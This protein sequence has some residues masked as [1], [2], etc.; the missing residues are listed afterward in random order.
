MR[1]TKLT[2][3]HTFCAALLCALVFSGCASADMRKNTAL[4]DVSQATA[5]Q[6]NRGTQMVKDFAAKHGYDKFGQVQTYA[7]TGSEVWKGMMGKMG[8]P[9]PENDPAF[10]M[11]FV[12][13]RMV[14][15]VELTNGDDAGTVYGVDGERVYTIEPGKEA[16]FDDDDL[17]AFNIANYQFW[18]EFPYRMSQLKN[19]TYGGEAMYGDGSYDLV[20]ATW[21]E[22]IDLNKEVDQYLLWF[23]KKTGRLDL[24]TFTY[25]SFPGMM[26]SSMY[27]TAI[28]RDYADRDGV[29]MPTAFIFQI[30]GP[31]ADEDDFAH[32]FDVSTVRFDPVSRE[33]LAAK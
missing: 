19:L 4:E 33:S 29:L 24:V 21:G 2:R 31:D 3:I 11:H 1:E 16:E 15:R 28:F 6:R 7:V 17:L 13:N 9:W 18:F 32:R 22:G 30:N 10:N 14:A 25:R 27:G 20:L 8:N 5:D 12:P 26:P 23:N